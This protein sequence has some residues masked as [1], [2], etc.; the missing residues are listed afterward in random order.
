[1]MPQTEV[2]GQAI[3]GSDRHEVHCILS[4]DAVSEASESSVTHECGVHHH[5][6]QTGERPG[7]LDRSNMVGCAKRP[8][9]MNQERRGVLGKYRTAA[10]VAAGVR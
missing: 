8:L 1:M 9:P 10:V 3:R 2:A 7:Q 6:G 4:R 5:Q